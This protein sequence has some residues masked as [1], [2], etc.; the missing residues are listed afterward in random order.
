[1]SIY[2]YNYNACGYQFII[3]ITIIHCFL[4]K[5]LS[6]SYTVYRKW[7]NSLDNQLNN[8]SFLL[9]INILH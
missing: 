4:H 7:I 5:L 2:Q 6:I 1:M 3:T 9:L 8:T